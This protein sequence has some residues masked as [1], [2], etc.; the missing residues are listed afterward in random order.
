MLEFYVIETDFN[1]KKPVR[2]NILNEYLVK[3]IRKKYTKLDVYY[4]IEKNL[5]MI[6]DYIIYRLFKK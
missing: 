4:Q 6:S 5:D 1:T 3:D 2:K